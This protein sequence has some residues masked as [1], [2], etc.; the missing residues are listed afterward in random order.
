MALFAPGDSNCQ[1]I[2]NTFAMDY[3]WM[4]NVDL[5]SRSGNGY[6]FN[7]NFIIEKKETFEKHRNKKRIFLKNICFRPRKMF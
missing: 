4:W 1:S 7:N 6:V 5:R 2:T 3:G